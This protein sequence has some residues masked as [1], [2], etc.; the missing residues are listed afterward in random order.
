M[1]RL[2][3]KMGLWVFSPVIFFSTWP[4]LSIAFLMCISC[5]RIVKVG[6]RKIVTLHLVSIICFFI[7]LA[8]SF[9]SS[10]YNSDSVVDIRNFKFFFYI[11]SLTLGFV[12]IKDNYLFTYKVSFFSFCSL[13]ILQYVIFGWSA[14]A[15]SNGFFYLPD[16]NNSM[17]ILSFLY[18]GIMSFYSV[19]KKLLVS[20]ITIFCMFIIGSRAGLAIVS[21]VFFYYFIKEV[22]PVGRIGLLCTLIL[23]FFYLDIKL[24]DIKTLIEFDSYSD[25]VRITLWEVGIEQFTNK[26]NIFFGM[27]YDFFNIYNYYLDND[28][29]HVHNIYLQVLFTTGILGFLAL[30]SFFFSW[31]Y[32]AYKQN[33]SVLLLQV[34]IIM[35]IGCVETI[36]SDSRVLIFICFFLGLSY[37][38]YNAKSNKKLSE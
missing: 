23:G 28:M 20:L 12:L 16:Q 6:L 31:I 7:I 19:H 37:I 36:Y 26:E 29:K 33:N 27:G 24:I 17:V 4:P 30:I 5:F 34:I 11:I 38:N 21:L 10:Y 8:M 3:S 14:E 35:L 25:R 15:R 9:F 1:N 2:S 18:P 32:A 13:L 22:R